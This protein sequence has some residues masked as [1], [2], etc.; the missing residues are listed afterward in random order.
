MMSAKKVGILA[1]K[2]NEQILELIDPGKSAFT[3]EAAY[4]D[5]KVE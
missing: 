5:L 1:V 3:G 4:I 2:A